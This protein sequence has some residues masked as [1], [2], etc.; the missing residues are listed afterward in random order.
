MAGGLID[1]D[2]VGVVDL[3]LDQAV[4]I[5]EG[6]HFGGGEGVGVLAGAEDDAVVHVSVDVVAELGV[7]VGDGEEARGGGDEEDDEGGLARAE[8]REAA[9]REG[10]EA[11]PD[12]EIGGPEPEGELF[13]GVWAVVGVDVEEGE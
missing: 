7:G 2:Q 1:G 6:A 11:E 13:E 12:D 3:E 9:A 5:V 4:D 8:T 10:G